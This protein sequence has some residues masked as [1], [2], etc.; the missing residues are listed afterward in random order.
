[1]A[2]EGEIVYTT[3]ATA[4]DEKKKDGFIRVIVAVKNLKTS[5][6]IVRRG[7]LP[8]AVKKAS[9]AKVKS[10]F[11]NQ[12]FCLTVNGDKGDL[13]GKHFKLDIKRL[14]YEIDPDKSYDEV[15]DDRVLLFLCKKQNK[16]WYPELD[17]GLETAEDE[18]EVVQTEGQT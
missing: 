5:T 9:N 3:P 2:D 11:E 16:S 17:N 15:D 18:E 8:K 13:K 14:P 12:S 4:C 6:D 10:T 7:I 1:M